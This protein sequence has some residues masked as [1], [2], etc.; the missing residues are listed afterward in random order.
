MTTHS[1]LESRP[2]SDPTGLRA[3]IGSPRWELAPVKDPWKA[4]DEVPESATV[5]MGC[6]ALTEGF[7]VTVDLCRELVARGH[8]VTPHLPA[9]SLDG[10]EHLAAVLDGYE[11][12]GVRDLFVVAGNTAKPAGPYQGAIDILEPIVQRGFTCGVTG[13]PEGHPFLGDPAEFDLLARKATYASYIATQTCFDAVTLRDWLERLRAAGVRTPVHLGVAGVVARGELLRLARWMGVGTSMR[14]INK[15]RKLAAKLAGGA[16]DPTELV[17][18]LARELEGN[19]LDVAGLHLN[20]FNQVAPTRDW[21][22][23]V[24]AGLT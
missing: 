19:D 2:G 9:R 18:D 17:F 5:A 20:T 21:I 23:E 22:M 10:P 16:Y 8:A 7:D 1:P 24:Q 14:F 11:R 4:I 3:L 12:C 6:F 13:Y 15:Q